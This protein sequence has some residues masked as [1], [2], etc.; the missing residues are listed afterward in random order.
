MTGIEVRPVA[1]RGDL[2]NWVR[3]PRDRVYGKATLWVPP[4][5]SDLRR[6]LNSGKNPF[7]RHG[8]AVPLLARDG[9]GRPVG[10]VLAHVYGRHNVR[11]QERTA[12]FGYFECVDDQSVCDGLIGAAA[13]YGEERGCTLLRGPFNMT[14]MQEMGVLVAGFEEPPAVDETYTAPYY[15]ALLEG[16]GLQRTFCHT[17]FRVDDLARVQPDASLDEWHQE[18]LRRDGIRVRPADLREWEREIETLRELLNDSFYANPH[19]VPITHEEFQFQ[20]GPYRRLIDPAIALVA[21]MEGV[22]CGFVIT[23]PD[24]NPLLKR[25]NGRLSPRSL[26]TFL[27]GRSR[28]RDACLIIMGVQRQLQGQGVM[29][30]LHAELVRALQRRDYRKL[31]ITWVSD[32]NARSL[33]SI[34][35]LGGRPLHRLTLFEAPIPLARRSPL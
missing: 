13:R 16:A 4:L 14:A 7:F 27:R 11:H 3:F 15:P 30:L 20:L 1:G 23:V 24:Y 31:T 10:R 29:R 28:V 8:E 12:F 33:A 2:D 6:A 32:A 19:F 5:D 35:A 25:M 17:T 18:G 21:E 26:F 34:V 22:P 9:S